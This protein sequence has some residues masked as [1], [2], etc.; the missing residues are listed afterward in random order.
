MEF[1][2]LAALEVANV[3]L[4]LVS[5]VENQWHLLSLLIKH[6][7]PGLRIWGGW[8][9][10]TVSKR[11]KRKSP[12]APFRIQSVSHSPLF[13]NLYSEFWELKISEKVPIDQTDSLKSI[14]T[15]Y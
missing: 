11:K 7:V 1:R 8:D 6:A 4:I 10:K 5:Y 14:E 15:I 2:S 12:L 9:C 3:P 13:P